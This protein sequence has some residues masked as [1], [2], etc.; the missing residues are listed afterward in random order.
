[1][2]YWRRQSH[3]YL[4]GDRAAAECGMLQDVLLWETQMRNCTAVY[5]ILRHKCAEERHL[6]FF[7]FMS[8]EL[9][10]SKITELTLQI[11]AGGLQVCLAGTN[12]GVG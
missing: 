6:I 8:V 10:L 4:K 12:P 11:C 9:T 3:H 2:Y 1:M 5:E 7:L